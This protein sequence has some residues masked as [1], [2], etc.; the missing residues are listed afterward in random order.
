MGRMIGIDLGTTNCCVAY[1]EGGKATVIPSPEGSRTVPSIVG[2]TEKGDRLVG[3]IAKRQMVT[4]PQNTVYAVKRLIGRKASDPEVIRAR[5]FLPYELTTA[6]NGD[7]RVRV[8][9]RDYSPPEISAIILT[10]LKELAED[11]LGEEV[12]EAVITVPAY[13]NDSQRQA[14]KDAG[15]IA[16]LQV[17]RILNEPT[18]ASLAYGLERGQETKI[19]VYDLGGGTFDISILRLAEGVFEV[20]ATSGDTFLGGEDFDQR[21]VAWLL[22]QFREAQGIDLSGDRLAMQRLKEAAEKAKIELS[23]VQEYPINLPFISADAT[24]PK[25]LNLTLTRAALEEMVAD[26]IERTRQPCLEAMQLADL[27]PAQIDEVLLV[28]GQTRTPRVVEMV[29]EIFGR[30]PNRDKNPDEVVGI[31][32]A[33]QSGILQGEVKDMVLLDVIPLSLGIETRGGTF[34]KL[35]DRGAT[36]PTRKAKIFTTVTDNQS[37]VEVH[38]LQGEREI[39]ARNKS[40]GKFDLVGIPAAP[41]GVPQI[42]V[43]FDIDSNGIVHVSAKDLATGREQRVVVNPSGGLT[44]AEIQQLVSEAQKHAEEDRVQAELARAR[45]RVEGLLESSEKSF[46]EFGNLLEEAKRKRVQEI[47]VA[48]RRGLQGSSVKEVSAGMEGLGE[49]SQILS[50]VILYKPAAAKPS[51]EGEGGAPRGDA[52]EG[53]S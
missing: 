22:A 19:A 5:E 43:S 1:M 3:Q 49:A 33:I 26:L 53:A 50:E 17:R 6:P 46:R 7:L 30:E 31:G 4:N 37:K 29:R 20:L 32:A 11:Q 27:G 23:T 25:H 48:T 35:L 24:G 38:V 14:T 36:I 16:G 34:T 41:R 39:A 8:R 52:G 28:G 45:A 2:F 9:G 12:S 15:R 44:E 18:A 51:P 10:R 13:F 40:L 42:E 21:I 47:L